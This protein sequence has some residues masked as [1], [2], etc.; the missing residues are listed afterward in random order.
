VER[1]AAEKRRR[2]I[3]TVQEVLVEEDGFGRTRGNAKVAIQG[4]ASIG[5]TVLVRIGTAERTTFD[6]QVI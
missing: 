6:G 2:W 3:G 1:I 4:R 5:E